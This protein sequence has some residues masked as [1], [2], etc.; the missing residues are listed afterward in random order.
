MKGDLDLAIADYDAALRT[1]S[2][3]IHL[4]TGFAETALIS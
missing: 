4:L 1:A 2:P 3:V